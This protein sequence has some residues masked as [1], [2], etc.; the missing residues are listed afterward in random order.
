MSDISPTEVALA[1]EAATPDRFA[2]FEDYVDFVL[3]V[4][5]DNIWGPPS[6]RCCAP[7]WTPM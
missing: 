7:P 3:S 1:A 6:T 2:S 5:P 4:L